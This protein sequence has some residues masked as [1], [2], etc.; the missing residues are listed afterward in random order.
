MLCLCQLIYSV[1][2]LI[3]MCFCN[4]ICGVIHKPNGLKLAVQLLLITYDGG[5]MAE[6]FVSLED[7]PE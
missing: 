7:V 6:G 4:F 2:V 3:L 5:T 1:L